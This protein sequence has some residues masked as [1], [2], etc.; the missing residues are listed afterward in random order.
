[1]TPFDLTS[2]VIGDTEVNEISLGREFGEGYRTPVP[3]LTFLDLRRT[4]R[5][6]HGG[7]GPEIVLRGPD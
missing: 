5:L 4:K 3:N 6:P 7:Q 1:M 2:D